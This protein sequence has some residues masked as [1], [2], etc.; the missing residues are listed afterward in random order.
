MSGSLLHEGIAGAVAAMP[1]LSSGLLGPAGRGWSLATVR[2]R[3][4][5]QQRQDEWQGWEWNGIAGAWN[6]D[7][8]WIY[9]NGGEKEELKV[10]AKRMY[11]Y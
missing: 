6:Q 1:S 5:S 7:Q 2:Y 9:T 4:H 3:E 11:D 8:E 10:S